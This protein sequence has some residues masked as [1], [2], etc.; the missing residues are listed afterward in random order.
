M[1]DSSKIQFTK[2]YERH[3]LFVMTIL[4][5]VIRTHGF[6][7]QRSDLE[8]LIQIGLINLYE[9]FNKFDKSKKVPF[10]SYAY[11]RVSGC[12]IDEFRK[13]SPIPRR[14]QAIYKEYHILKNKSQESGEHFSEAH[15]ADELGI[16]VAKLRSY[17]YIWESRHPMSI[18]DEDTV[19]N[20]T[21]A[22]EDPEHLLLDYDL[23]TNILDS[24]NS[25]S[26]IERDVIDLIFDKG[27]SLSEIKK[28]I[29]LSEGRISQIKKTAIE[30]IRVQVQ[31]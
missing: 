12:F 19:L 15:A 31:K 4:R 13:N 28:K 20:L 22:T 30:K 10:E 7:A 24:F 25:L 21:S 9:C 6:Q 14:Q 8:D 1:S 2:D 18:D 3:R 29:G 16:S 23:K 26:P 17:L 11:V 5:S 27:M